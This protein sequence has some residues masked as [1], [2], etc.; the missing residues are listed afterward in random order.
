ML[1]KASTCLECSAALGTSSGIV[2]DSSWFD[3][4][5]VLRKAFF[6]YTVNVPIT[7]VNQS[8]LLSSD[9]EADDFENFKGTPSISALEYQQDRIRIPLTNNAVVYEDDLEITPFPAFR[10]N[11]RI[12]T[13][14]NLIISPYNNPMRLYQ[15]SSKNSCF[16]NS[17][18]GKIIVGGNV[19]NGQT[20]N[21]TEVNDVT[22]D[23][24]D[25]DQ[26]DPITETLR[27]ANDSTTNNAIEVMYDTQQYAE[28]INTLVDD[29]EDK[30]TGEERTTL[31]KYFENRTRKVPWRDRG[32]V[33]GTET[34]SGTT[35]DDLKPSDEE[36][37]F[38]VNDEGLVYDEL[39][40]DTQNNLPA[41][42]PEDE[43]IKNGKEK[44]IGDRIL[45]GNNLPLEVWD[46]AEFKKAYEQ[47]V[48]PHPDQPP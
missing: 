25:G 33:S 28:L 23:I 43:D 35:L 29:A 41:T 34:V 40:Y 20:D 12:I 15:V 32:D 30:V 5:E 48:C 37:I 42:N 21:T 8:N 4:G 46:G 19:V 47:N 31:E 1:E 26:Q 18:N 38:S 2:G 27:S 7:N 36:W 39:V 9:E 14:S 24:F 45:V 22:V 13:N 11:G 17:E 44:L 6:V 3:S 10:L 16:Y